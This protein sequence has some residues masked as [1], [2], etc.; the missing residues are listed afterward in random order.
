[1][2]ECTI[3]DGDRPPSPDRLGQLPGVR[4]ARVENH[5]IVVIAEHVHL[6][7]PALLT[8]LDEQGATLSMLTTH[9]ATLEDVFVSLTGRHLRET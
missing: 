7:L 6:A 3:A 8:T 9:H 2:I 4:E 5:G 1:V